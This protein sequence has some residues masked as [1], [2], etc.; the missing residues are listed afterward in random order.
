MQQR[1]LRAPSCKLP[2]G[3]DKRGIGDALCSLRASE[4]GAAGLLERAAGLLE[5]AGDVLGVLVGL[6]DTESLLESQGT[7][8]DALLVRVDRFCE[9]RNRAERNQKEDPNCQGAWPP[10]GC[11]TDR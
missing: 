8:R 6:E 4:I 5:R 11:S 1:G 2:V 9:A 3:E 10:E 7:G